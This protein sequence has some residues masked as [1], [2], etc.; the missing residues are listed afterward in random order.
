[1][2]RLAIL[3]HYGCPTSLLDVSRNF[4]VACAFAFAGPVQGQAYLR[5]YAL[6]RHQRAVTV[7]DALDTVVVD[8][9]AELTSFCSRPHVQQAAFI[10]RRS[11]VCS[12]LDGSPPAPIDSATV[13]ALCIA[14][15]RLDFP[16]AP[17]FFEPRHN[18]GV[19]Y[20]RAGNGCRVC[21]KDADMNGDYL[22]HILECYA[23]EYPD[24]KPAGFP[25]KLAKT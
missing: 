17:R 5:V 19:L 12:D 16:G 10:A 1:L 11:A 7:L 6:P 2:A 24:G 25:D 8:L 23:R 14:H 15:L 3:Q 21:K 18:A 22:L 13:D 4:E 9:A 20:P